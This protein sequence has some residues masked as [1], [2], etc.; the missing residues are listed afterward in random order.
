MAHGDADPECHG[1][2]QEDAPE[3]QSRGG[4]QVRDTLGDQHLE[5]VDR[6][7]R[8]ADEGRARA[9]RDRDQGREADATRQHQQDRDQRDDLLLHVLGDTAGAEEE[10]HDRDHEEILA[11]QGSDE[12]RDGPPQR[13]A[14]V[15]DGERA[16]DQEDE[17]DHVGGLGH[18]ER[19]GHDRVEEIHGTRVYR[20]VRAR[21]YDAPSRRRVRRPLVFASRKRVARERGEDHASREKR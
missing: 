21:D 20:L 13:A 3:P 17:E 15:D 10:R 16:S 5:R 2:D 1:Q 8:G 14:L 18:S 4:G 11:P 9:H 6:A 7:E 12:R 19:Q